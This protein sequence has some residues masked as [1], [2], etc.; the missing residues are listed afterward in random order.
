MERVLPIEHQIRIIILAACDEYN[1][2]DDAEVD[3]PG[4]RAIGSVQANMRKFLCSD[5][6]P[7]DCCFTRRMDNF[8]AYFPIGGEL[9]GI[10]YQNIFSGAEGKSSPVGAFKSLNPGFITAVPSC[11]AR[12]RLTYELPLDALT[13]ETTELLDI[14]IGRLLE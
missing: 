12:E 4:R 1:E 5:E 6:I 8:T 11:A 9:E 10:T 7:Q 3:N 14:N 2:E 13:G